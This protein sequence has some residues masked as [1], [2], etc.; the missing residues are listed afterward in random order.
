MPITVFQEAQALFTKNKSSA[1]PVKS[2]TV[3]SELVCYSYQACSPI[4]T[5]N[6]FLS[7]W[8]WRPHPQLYWHTSDMLCHLAITPLYSKN[9]KLMQISIGLLD[10]AHKNISY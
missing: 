8:R 4:N 3:F 10:R 1:Q 6:L 9:T 2:A 7:K 5:S